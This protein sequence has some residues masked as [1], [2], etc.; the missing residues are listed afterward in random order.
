MLKL[1]DGKFASMRYAF[2]ED[3]SFVSE[4]STKKAVGNFS[5]N[6]T[7][8]TLELRTKL[9]T[10]RLKIKKQGENKLSIFFGA[11]PLAFKKS[12]THANESALCFPVVYA[13]PEQLVGKWTLIEQETLN[14]YVD[15]NDGIVPFSDYFVEFKAD[16]DCIIKYTKTKTKGTWSLAEEPFQLKTIVD[17]QIKVY[18]LIHIDENQ[19]KWLDSELKRTSTF[20]KQN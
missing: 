18:T 10:I 20:L 8:D 4:S 13:K 3:S 1:L 7:Q 15:D 14:I 6:N 11:M 12:E 5:L 17:N 16:G 9:S 19:L 2:L